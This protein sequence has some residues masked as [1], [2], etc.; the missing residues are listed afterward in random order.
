MTTSSYGTVELVVLEFPHDA[1]PPQVR[2]EMALLVHRPQVRLI[3]LV[4]VRRPVQGELEVAEATDVGTQLGLEGLDLIGAG[5]VG[6]EDI[7]EVGESLQPGTSAL[8]IVL[9]HLWSKGLI[10]S[11]RGAGGLVLSTERIPTEVVAAVIEA[12]RRP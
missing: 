4:H 12:P 5:L 2:D 7:D 3:D 1:I 9:E 11:I 8:L 10:E 6:Q